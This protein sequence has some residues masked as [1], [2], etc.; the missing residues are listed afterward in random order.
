MTDRNTELLQVAGSLLGQVALTAG[1]SAQGWYII[2]ANT[3]VSAKERS[4]RG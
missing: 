3:P 1:L 2:T 4:Y